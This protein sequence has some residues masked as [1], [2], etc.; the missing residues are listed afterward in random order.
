MRGLKMKMNEHGFKIKLIKPFYGHNSWRTKP[1]A[2]GRVLN[3]SANP[4]RG[5]KLIKQGI[6][7]KY[8]YRNTKTD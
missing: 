7:I 1:L 2:V 3:Y 6:A 8:E 4:G 5:I